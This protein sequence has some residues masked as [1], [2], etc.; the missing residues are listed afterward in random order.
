MKH[1]MA[2]KLLCLTIFLL[3]GIP[4]L[5]IKIASLPI[6]AIDFLLLATFMYA[7]RMHKVYQG[8]T[9][10]A[11]FMATILVFAVLG[12]TATIITYGEPL[13][14]IYLIV[15]ELLAFSL[16]FSVSRIIRTVE[17]I[18]AVIKAALI[19]LLVTAS[20]M[21]LSSM[22]ITRGIATA[23]F[24]MNFLVPDSDTLVKMFGVLQRE[25][26][27]RGHSLVGMSILSGAFLN[28]FWP[29][30][31]LLYRWPGIPSMWKQLALIGTL[32][33]PFGVVMG[34]S[35][36]ALV[37][38]IFVVGGVLFFGSGRIRRGIIVAVLLGL[39]VFSAVGWNSDLFFFD[40]IEHRVNAMIDNPYVDPRETER[41]YSY[42]EPFEHV[43][44]HPRFLLIGEGLS[45]R[46]IPES[47]GGERAG[48]NYHSLF[49]A[50]YYAY[51]MVAAFIFVFLVIAG[52]LFVW[53]QI[54]RF[55]QQG[56]SIPLLCAQALFASMLGMLPWLL[57]GHAVVTLPRGTMLF[58]LLFGLAASL[59]NFQEDAN[60]SM[61]KEA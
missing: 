52:F 4:R 39:T 41:L 37:G 6:Y 5:N 23:V 33:F 50:A 24:S 30:V 2:L 28:S 20:M 22:P 12:E 31:A 16:F 48:K 7:M 11:G 53:K 47:H 61:G 40:R 60:D 42:T 3:L 14:P 9:P 55:R 15:R 51:G 43:V 34:Y 59:K 54:W 25:G 58:C 8:K 26:G 35:R 45:V 36:G 19:G 38:L 56:L 57:L 13:Q 29:L 18:Q 46:K 1:A 10:L 49:A 44:E 32:L 27:M 17:D 21:I